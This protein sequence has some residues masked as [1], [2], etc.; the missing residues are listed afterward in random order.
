MAQKNTCY[1]CKLWTQCRKEMCN[2]CPNKEACCA[3]TLNISMMLGRCQNKS[4]M[5]RHSNTC[6]NHKLNNRVSF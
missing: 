3:S 2:Y 1:N 4:E 5:L 6:S